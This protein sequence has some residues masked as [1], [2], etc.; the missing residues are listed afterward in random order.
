MLS[1]SSIGKSG[2]G[3]PPITSSL[4][5]AIRRI[6]DQLRRA[7]TEEGNWWPNLFDCE[8]QLRSI[9]LTGA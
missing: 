3:W 9:D 5:E 2:Y 1:H 7:D 6:R 4:I 8:G